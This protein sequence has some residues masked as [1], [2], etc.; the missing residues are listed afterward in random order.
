MNFS[1]LLGIF[2]SSAAAEKTT[3]RTCDV[4]KETNFGLHFSTEKAAQSSDKQKLELK[5]FVIGAGEI[6]GCELNE[7]FAL[8]GFWNIDKHKGVNAVQATN[9]DIKY[10]SIGPRVGQQMEIVYTATLFIHKK[11]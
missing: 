1:N 3:T 9:P 6:G 10:K 2:D 7:K 5:L 4:Q 8:I 11:L